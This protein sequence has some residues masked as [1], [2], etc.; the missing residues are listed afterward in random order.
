[1]TQPGQSNMGSWGGGSPAGDA[2]GQYNQGAGPPPTNIPYQLWT[3][4]PPSGVSLINGTQNLLQ[5]TSPNDG[6]LH[7][8]KVHY[9]LKES[10]Y[11]GGVINVVFTING[12]QVTK[13]VNPGNDSGANIFR[14]GDDASLNTQGF[15]PAF[16]CDP[17]TTITVVQATAV[18]SG[19]PVTWWGGILGL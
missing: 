11:T 14:T 3:R 8:F 7:F 12:T 13:Q 5:A 15:S 17:N 16:A 6:Q 2:A 19:G 10:L 9:S 18:S 1:M 4:T